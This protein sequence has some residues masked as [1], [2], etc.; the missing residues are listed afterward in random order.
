MGLGLQLTY[1]YIQHAVV[2]SCAFPIGMV[3]GKALSQGIHGWIYS[4]GR[5]DTVGNRI[6]SDRIGS[7]VGLSVSVS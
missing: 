4:R 5:E 1:T 2:A 7:G 6:G 3:G